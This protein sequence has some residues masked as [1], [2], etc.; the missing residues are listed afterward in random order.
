MKHNGFPIALSF[1]ELP[2]EF[3]RSIDN[4]SFHILEDWPKGLNI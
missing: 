3:V 4:I 2:E 1:L